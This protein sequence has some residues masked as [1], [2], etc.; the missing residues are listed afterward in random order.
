M[1]GPWPKGASRVV[2]Q[3][4]G[5]DRNGVVEGELGAFQPGFL[6]Q[7]RQILFKRLKP[8]VEFRAAR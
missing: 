3:P 2:P 7:G 6:A 5:N 8:A 4:I 1:R